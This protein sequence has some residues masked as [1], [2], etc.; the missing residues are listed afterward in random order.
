[1]L[2]S[3]SV[4]RW[5]ESWGECHWQSA[6]ERRGSLLGGS[7]HVPILIAKMRHADKKFFKNA[8]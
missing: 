5:L 4:T 2:V 7:F 1:M 6:P 8:A 3:W